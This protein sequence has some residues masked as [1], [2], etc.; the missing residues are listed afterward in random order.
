[1]L[2]DLLVAVL[3]VAETSLGVLVT[4]GVDD[5]DELLRIGVM[6]VHLLI[7]EADGAVFGLL[8][9]A[10]LEFAVE[11]RDTK[12]ELIDH[13]S[14]APPVDLLTVTTARIDLRGDVFTRADESAGQILPVD[15]LG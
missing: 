15:F 9:D 2:Q 5:V 3:A 1:M 13:D 12:D 14:N 8:F 7:W 6:R 10:F 11:R 4:Q